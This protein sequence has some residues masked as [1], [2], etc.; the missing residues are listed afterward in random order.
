MNQLEESNQLIVKNSLIVY[1][2]LFITT[3]IGLITSRFVLQ[4]LGASDYGLY[5]VVGGVIAIFAVIA[6]SMS[7]TTIR[8]LN[9]ELGKPEGDPNKVFNICQVTHI[10]FAIIILILSETIGLFYILKYLNVEAGKEADAMFVFQVSTIVACI[11]V[12]NVPYQS[13]FIAKE[14]FTH[15]AVIDIVNALIKLGL[16]LALLYYRGNALRLYAIIMSVSTLVSFVVYHFLGYRYWPLLTKWK[17]VKRFR[18]YKEVLVYN[19][20][21]MLASTALIG[22]SQGSNMLMNFFFGTV[23]NGAYGLARTVQS[24]VEVF[25]VNF[26]SAAAPQI[27]QSVGSGD[28]ERASGL[29]KKICRMC[30]LLSLLIVFPLYVEMG[31]ILDIWLDE[32]PENTVLF[33]RILLIA[34][35]VASTGG[36]LLR[37]KD[38][39]GKIKYFM[40]TYSFWYFLTLPIGY[41]LFEIGLPPQTILILFVITDVICRI[42]QLVLMKL[43]YHYN[44]AAF[45]KEAYVRP[46]MVAV[47]MLLYLM[48]YNKLYFENGWQHLLGFVFAFLI[49]AFLIWCIG[50]KSQERK[51]IIGFIQ[52]LFKSRN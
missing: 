1:V 20:Y 51:S 25:T 5:N 39:L 41:Y 52:G 18:E 47:L 40:L 2:R 30:Q 10:A 50:I 7:S 16:I 27:T 22:R 28:I 14:K 37:L 21:N 43:V 35:F 38:A 32:V 34:V 6:G 11:G 24:F 19:N 26:D 48:V 23:V 4:A 13:V 31:F 45:C 8:F 9:I 33:C 12:I 36:G 3:I 15:I 49:G 46:L 17:V 29:A 42:T 44:I